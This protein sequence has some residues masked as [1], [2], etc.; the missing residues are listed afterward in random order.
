MLVVIGGKYNNYL[1][2]WPCKVY[3]YLLSYVFLTW[4]GPSNTYVHTYICTLCM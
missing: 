2:Y 1:A 4:V 3:G